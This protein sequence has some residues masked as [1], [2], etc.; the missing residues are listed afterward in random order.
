[1][2]Y[3]LF[4]FLAM[5]SAGANAIF[6]KF[7][8]VKTTSSVSSLI[9]STFM[10]IGCFIVTCILGHVNDLYSLTNEQWLFIGINGLL[11][12]VD[13]IFY[14]AAMK[15]SNLEAFTPFNETAQLFFGNIFFLI[16]MFSITTNGGRP[17]TIALYCGGLT[18]LFVALFVIIFSKK[19]NPQINKKW[20]IFAFLAAISYAATLLVMKLKLSDV[21]SDVI[22]FHQ[23][24]VVVVVSLL[25]TLVKKEW[26]SFQVIKLKGYL[27]YFVAA[28]FNTML[29]I[30]R[31]QALS[32]SNSIP[33]IVN[34]IVSLEF[35][36]V[37][38]ITIFFKKRD[39]KLITFIIIVLVCLGMVL[40][41]LSGIL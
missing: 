32:Y 6:N 33:S 38:I 20:V 22:S 12:S 30:F 9:K 24:I 28:I 15:R 21:A 3:V 29:M 4:A 41:M 19:L 25:T 11:T 31:Y 18:F 8:S 5:C 2:E 16:F 7:A 35:V 17:L 13:W 27:I 40:N 34:V 39:D 14:F 36:I 1:M 26:A 10:V 37:A 23:M